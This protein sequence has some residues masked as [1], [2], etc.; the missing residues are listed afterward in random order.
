DSHVVAADDQ[1]EEPTLAFTFSDRRIIATLAVIAAALF[2]FAARLRLNEQPWGDE[3]HYLIMSI[4]L[5]KYHTF[6]LTQ[7]YANRDYWSFYPMD[8]D[9]HVYP[10][11]DGIMVPLHNFGGPMLWTLPFVLWGR[12][13]AAGVVVVASVLTVINIYWLLREL[14]I[15][16]PYA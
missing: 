14:G 4:S 13:G 15:V 7:A 8:I 3:P 5:G 6:D 12:A 2:T 16:K 9:A 1:R 10:N 11:A